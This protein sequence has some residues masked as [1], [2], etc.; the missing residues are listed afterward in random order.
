MSKFYDGV[1]II[2]LS[3]FAC[4]LGA[5]TGSTVMEKDYQMQAISNNFAHWE[6]NNYGE[7]EFK[8]NV[9]TNNVELKNK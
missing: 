7:T 4:G 9:Q 8:W 5:L 6:V 2:L 1:V 3:I